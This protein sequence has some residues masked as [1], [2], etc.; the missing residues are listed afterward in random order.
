MALEDIGIEFDLQST[1]LET[2][3]IYIKYAL[4][5]WNPKHNQIIDNTSFQ[6]RKNIWLTPYVVF[7]LKL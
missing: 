4:E 2:M 5:P 1:L 3:K 7:L 6:K